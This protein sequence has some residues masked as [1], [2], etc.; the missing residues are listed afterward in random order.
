MSAD[1]PSQR[2]KK[3]SG[4]PSTELR[5]WAADK[6]SQACRV[7]AGRTKRGLA[8]TPPSGL[9]DI[10]DQWIAILEEHD[11]AD[12]AFKLAALAWEVARTEE[13]SRRF[14]TGLQRLHY[15]AKLANHYRGDRELED[16]K[17]VAA[18]LASE[19]RSK[20]GPQ[21][22]PRTVAMRAY[23]ILAK[24]SR[25]AVQPD[26]NA[27]RGRLGRLLDET[28]SQKRFKVAR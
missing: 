6:L 21:P 13:T 9:V 14:G 15:I 27:R 11:A 18:A 3:W 19:Q 23:F 12:L 26:M 20:R 24:D 2:R 16:F 7:Y 1:R 10:I 28:E 25:A 22:N 4:T 17:D 5:V 8:H